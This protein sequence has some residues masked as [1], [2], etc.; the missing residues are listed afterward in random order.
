MGIKLTEVLKKN[1]GYSQFRPQQ[2]DIITSVLHQK[3]VL[4]LMPT[5]GGKSICFQLPALLMENITLVISPLISLMKDQVESLRQNGISAAYYNSTLSDMDKEIL[6]R[7]CINGDIKLLY[8]APE[9]LFQIKDTWLKHIKISLI[10]IDEAHCVSMWG[11]DFRPEYQ[12]IG[13]LR[14]ELNNIP[15]IAL[16]ATADK[17][18][19]K[20]IVKQLNLNEPELFLSS[21][22]RPNLSLAVKSQVPKQKKVKEVIKFINDRNGQSGIIYCLSRK[23]TEKWAETLQSHGIPANYYHAGLPSDKRSKVQEDFIKD[24]VPVI[25]ATIAFG[26]GIDK[27]NVRWVIH[28]N[29]PKNLEG[30]YQEIGRA[31]RD[32]LPSDTLLYYNYRDVVLLNDFVKESEFKPIYQ[33]KINRILQYAEATSCRRKILLSYFSEHLEED[34]KNCDVCHNPPKII[35]GTVIAQKSLSAVYRTNQKVGINTCVNILRGAKNIKVFENNYQTLKTY[36]V[37]ADLAFKDWQHYITQLIN[38]GV[39]EIAYDENF[40]LKITEFGGEILKGNKAINLTRPIDQKVKTQKTKGLKTKES[41][42]NKSSGIKSGLFEQLKALRKTIATKKGVPAYIIFHDASLKEIAKLKPQNEEEMME[43]QGMGEAKFYT[44]G[45]I[46]LDE[47]ANFIKTQPK[48]K[49]NQSTTTIETLELFE[50]GLS[51]DEIA[52]TKNVSQQ[53]I[54]NHLIKLKEEG[55]PIDLSSYVTNDEIKLVQSIYKTLNKPDKLKPIYDAL[56]GELNYTKIKLA[57]IH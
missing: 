17:I 19:R 45:Q 57:L 27:S 28:N 1:F 10:A 56:K 15:F 36:G 23:E 11:H 12:K 5:G 55:K 25:C 33:E 44:Y 14:K 54:F 7:E 43:I 39:F 18:T 50:K 26:M 52:M 3:D 29:L 16:T 41:K 13:S 20:D 32:G 24:D 4:V 38:L 30:F 51:V 8:M 46:F 9:T 31:G 35:D 6:A 34:C 49:S 40:Y 22:N 53:T 47:V 37:G 2:E 21:F 48:K 42:I